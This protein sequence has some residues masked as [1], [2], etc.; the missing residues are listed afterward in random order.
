M[1]D[2]NE[3][4]AFRARLE[5]EQAAPSRRSPIQMSRTDIARQFK[6]ESKKKEA[7][8]AYNV[9]GTV[10]DFGAKVGLPPA[11]SAGLGTGANFLTNAVPGLFGGQITGQTVKP[12]ANM[13]SKE[14]MYSALKPSSVNASVAENFAKVNT[15]L[16]GGYNVTAGGV[17]KMK[18]RVG[19]LEDEIRN[20]VTQSPERVSL[21]DVSKESKGVRESFLLDKDQKTVDRIFEEMKRKY[22]PKGMSMEE[23][24]A[25][26]QKIYKSVKDKAF[27][28]ELQSAEKESLMGVARGIR[29]KEITVPGVEA[30]LAEQS[31]LLEVLEPAEKR[32]IAELRN[33][34]AGLSL[35]A[36]NPKLMALYIGDRSSAFKS[37]L[38]NL[39]NQSR[40]SPLVGTAGTISLQ[41]MS[42]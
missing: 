40:V 11:M 13:L 12:I 38:A 2:E 9:G 19:A 7:E 26:K 17:E 27:S 28:G 16:E 32:A 21:A 18:G 34:P 15:M 35:L 23:A 1:A 10:T 39:I 33:N 41:E 22:F 20:L 14:L 8:Q 4:F 42:R 29:G 30:R 31:R 3:E 5:R 6:E 36:H 24:H 37:V 25:L